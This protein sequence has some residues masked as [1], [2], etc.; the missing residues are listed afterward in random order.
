MSLS[1]QLLVI[2]ATSLPVSN[3]AADEPA[4]KASEYVG[5]Y[6]LAWGSWSPDADHEAMSRYLPPD[7]IELS[8]AGGR[9]LAPAGRVIPHRDPSTRLQ[10]AYWQEVERGQVAI[11]WSTGFSGVMLLLRPDAGVLRG[12]AKVHFDDGGSLE[13]TAVGSPERCNVGQQGPDPGRGGAA[14]RGDAPDKALN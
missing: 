6:R 5:C 2:V 8:A 3:A 11:V 13:T 4:S 9:D 7:V 10:W 12:K 14:Q 1:T